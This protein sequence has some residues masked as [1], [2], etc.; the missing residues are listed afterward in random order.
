MIAGWAWTLLNLY[1]VIS[2]CAILFDL[3]VL[4]TAGARQRAQERRSATLQA[5][6]EGQLTRVREGREPDERLQGELYRRLRHIDSVLAFCDLADGYSA[7][8][9]PAFA[10]YLAQS[11]PLFARLCRR[12]GGSQKMY[13][14][15]FAWLLASCR[16]DIPAA[17]PF[18]LACAADRRSIYCRENALTALY[19]GGSQDAVIRA[20]KRMSQEDIHHSQKLLTD[21]L[22]SFCGDRMALCGRLWAEFSALSP[23]LRLVT[24]DLMR[25]LNA[26]Y[27]EA[28][29]PLLDDAGTDDELCYAVLRY[30]GR[31]TYPPARARMLRFLAQ[32]RRGLWEYAAVSASALRFYRGEDV[33]PALLAALSDHNWYV[34]YNAAESL[35]FMGLGETSCAAVL[36]GPDPYAAD[37]LRYMLDRRRL[38]DSAA[39]ERGG[40]SLAH[41]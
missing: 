5:L 13:R 17:G 8:A 11:G 37:I 32:P 3:F 39:A 12:Y 25:F 1:L 15:S 6:L 4:L 21:G 23:A 10:R 30:Y 36:E 35:V 24:V 7:A 27:R 19:R 28:L 29:F 33:T 20:L 9:D 16:Q 2:L 18:L 40:A 26:D 31:C 34:R 14:A 22:L 38:A 41:A